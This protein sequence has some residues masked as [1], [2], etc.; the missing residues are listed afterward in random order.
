MSEADRPAAVTPGAA[1]DQQCRQ[2]VSARIWCC[3]FAVIAAGVLFRIQLLDAFLLDFDECMHFEVAREPT[4]AATLQLSRFHTH[5]PLIFLLHHALLPFGDSEVA[6]RMPA[7]IFGI[8]ALLFAFLWL[9]EILGPGPALAGLTFLTFSMPMIHLSAQMRSYMTLFTFMFAALYFQERFF[10]QRAI[11][12]LF[13]SQGLLLLGLLTH[14]ATAWLLLL[15][16]ILML[17]RAACGMLTRRELVVWV[18]GQLTLLTICLSALT[19]LRQWDGTETENTMW[20]HWHQA[21]AFSPD[22]TPP[23]RLAVMRTA[24]F[25]AFLS[26]PW[27]K[28][29]AAAIVSGAILFGRREWIR[30]RS[31]V[32]AAERV[33][34]ILLP[35]VIAMVLLHLRIY[36]VGSSRHS[37]WLAPFVAAGLASAV[38]P[39]LRA[40]PRLSG[41]ITAIFLA[42]WVGSYAWPTVWNIQTT[43]TPAMMHQTVDLIRRHVPRGATI[44]TDQSSRFVLRYYMD[45]EAPNHIRDIG[46]RYYEFQSDSYRLVSIPKFHFFMYDLR[47]EWETFQKTIGESATDPLWVVYLG[48]GT[49][50]GNLDNILRRFPPGRLIRRHTCVDNQI[51]L[52]QF[53]PQSPGLVSSDP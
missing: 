36:P 24:E 10:R 19:H 17:L 41:T 35:F 42:G 5:P 7:M 15:L 25:I 49:R 34:L 6:L 13:L 43:Q 33:F 16:G 39:V 12:D 40:S 31:R 47:S 11:R 48:F 53:Q 21:S 52:V 32:L 26:G 38:A 46:D 27:W 14:Y 2:T 3:V 20:D 30:T 37:M 4:F 23:L 1:S 51:M 50:D 18:C 29:F 22:S 45:P 8:A 9:N 44:L 28:V